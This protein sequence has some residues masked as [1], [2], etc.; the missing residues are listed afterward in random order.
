MEVGTGEAVIQGRRVCNLGPVLEGVL[1]GGIRT[2]K[3]VGAGRISRM[4]EEASGK[5]FFKKNEGL[6]LG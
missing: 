6:R 2:C 4:E 3:G 1:G 5:S